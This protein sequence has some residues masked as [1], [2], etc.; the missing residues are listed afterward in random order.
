ML[1]A[2][3]LALSRASSPVST[4]YSTPV[5]RPSTPPMHPPPTSVSQLLNPAPCSPAPSPSS[6]EVPDGFVL[7][8]DGRVR[9]K[10]GRKPTPGLSDADRRQA[11]LLKNRRTAEV[12]RRRK[13]AHLTQLTAQRDEAAD[14]VRRLVAAHDALAA[15]LKS[16]ESCSGSKQEAHGNVRADAQ[17]FIDSIISGG[18]AEDS[19]PPSSNSSVCSTV[20]VPDDVPQPRQ[21]IPTDLQ[22][23]LLKSSRSTPKEFAS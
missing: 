21:Q 23:S 12:S 14:L 15:K 9:K 16:P 1:Q 10:R 19:R 20:P 4:G 17:R 22:R 7:G 18:P 13:L 8:K 3:S 5:E 11:R 2:A 6:P